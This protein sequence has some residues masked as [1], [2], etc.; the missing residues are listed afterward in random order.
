MP[1]GPKLLAHSTGAAVEIPLD[2]FGAAGAPG[3]LFICAEFEGDTRAD[4][5][6]LQDITPR[7][8]VVEVQLTKSLTLPDSLN[9][10][11]GPN[12][13]KAAWLDHF[14]MNPGSEEKAIEILRRVTADFDRT[15]GSSITPKLEK[16]LEAA[17]KGKPPT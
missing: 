6:R 12:G 1:K 13:S 16:A 14:R 10:A 11:F 3:A 7:Q 17:G 2:D 8:F 9:G 4:A 5:E 15:Q